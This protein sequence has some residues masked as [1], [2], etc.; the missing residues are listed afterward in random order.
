MGRRTRGKTR[1]PPQLIYWKC[2]KSSAASPV[3][4]AAGTGSVHFDVRIKRTSSS[5][6]HS[7]S[8]SNAHA[9]SLID[10]ILGKGNDIAQ[11]IYT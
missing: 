3:D 6:H 2:D 11:F 8:F 10:I 5:K 9:F 4:A 7:A 1:A